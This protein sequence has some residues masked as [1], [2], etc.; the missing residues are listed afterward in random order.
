[1]RRSLVSGPTPL[2]LFELIIMPLSLFQ[3]YAMLSCAEILAQLRL[4]IKNT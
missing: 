1:M 3:N 2:N 4:L